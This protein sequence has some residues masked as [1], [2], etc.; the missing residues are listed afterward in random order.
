MT[1]VVDDTNRIVGMFTD[2]DLRRTLDQ[3]I[4]F[5][6][7]RI[8]DV[9]TTECITV[10]KESLAEEAVQIMESRRVNSF[11]IA[12]E[13]HKLIGAL[14]MHDLLQAGVV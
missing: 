4:D 7:C 5:H 11:L 10:P 3:E 9:M 13:E 1:A 6:Q 12:D 2:G 8:K 14:N